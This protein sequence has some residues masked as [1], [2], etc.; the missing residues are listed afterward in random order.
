M[1]CLYNKYKNV[2]DTQ[3]FDKIKINDSLT[4]ISVN[5][6]L[7]NYTIDKLNT[8]NQINFTYTN[9]G[10]P[11]YVKIIIEFDVY[12]NFFTGIVEQILPKNYVETENIYL[13]EY[14]QI[15]ENKYVINFITESDSFVINTYTD[16]TVS[17]CG[18]EYIHF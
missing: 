3:Q 11:L 14:V 2:N 9:K 15:G 16:A 10:N 1:I 18:C 7:F 13:P 6:I 8:H 12:Q 5:N 4:Q 17:F